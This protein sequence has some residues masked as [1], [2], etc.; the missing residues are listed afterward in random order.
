[1]L[2]D[3]SLINKYRRELM[4][5]AILW[6]T[7]YHCL[8]DPV[9]ALGIPVLGTVLSR[10]WLGV[11]IFLFLSGIGLFFSMRRNPDAKQYWLRRSKKVIV[12]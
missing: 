12:P 4:G 5:I 6:I 11:E 7:L 3:L 8:A 9:K 10:G 1:M 2:S